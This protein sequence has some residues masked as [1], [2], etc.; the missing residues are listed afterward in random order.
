MD[1]GSASWAWGIAAVSA[2]LALLALGALW[3][4]EPGA[5]PPRLLRV[6][7]EPPSESVFQGRDAVEGTD[8]TVSPD[9]RRLAFVADD[10]I[11]IRD[12]SAT[13]PAPLPG[14]ESGRA[15]FWAPDGETLG[16][17]AG[18]MLRRVSGRG[19][20]VETIC[21]AEDGHGGSWGPGDQILFAPG[22]R[23]PILA[24][25]AGGGHPR[26][27]TEL[28]GSVH[29]THR[30]P[31]I[32]P[33]GR[34]FLFFA[35]SHRRPRGQE[36]GIYVASVAGGRARRL[37]VADSK[38][39]LSAGW[40]LFLRDG[41][42]MAQQFNIAGLELWGDAVRLVEDV[43][44]LGRS[45]AAMFSASRRDV[46]VYERGVAD[47]RIRLTWVDRLGN[48]VD[49]LREDLMPWDLRLSPDDSR[50]ALAAGPREPEIWIDELDGRGGARLP[51]VARFSR[52]PVWSPDGDQLAFAGLREGGHLGLFVMAADGTGE[53]RLLLDSAQDQ[54]PTSWSAD[55][56]WLA[57]EQGPAESTEIWI[58]PMTTQEVP[59][60]FI[61]DA[62]PAS[63]AQFSPDGRWLMFTSRDS[64]AAQVYITPFPGGG[65]RW[66]ISNGTWAGHGRWSAD[67]SRVFYAAAGSMMMEVA[68]RRRKRDGGLDIGVPRALFSFRA[69]DSV[70]RGSHDFYDVTG[71]EERF[72]IAQGVQAE[73]YQGRLMLVVP[74]TA[75][76][77]DGTVEG[78]N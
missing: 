78:G 33:D 48:E 18:G 15:P 43:R 28:D 53:A 77:E 21:E 69:N 45:W 62:G 25:D 56:R 9:G 24:V 70:Y 3:R 14:T 46:L 54:V 2:L 31:E 61:Q 10:Q 13:E 5:S 34:H 26:V 68:V 22:P 11:W 8:V 76:L 50:L 52:A 20:E 6:T 41:D 65:E 1:E 35:A 42:L 74:W 40:L 57:F 29:S 19:G 30:W 59:S 67:G 44:Y 7:L 39:V 27:V 55:G 51:G 4:P 23:S 73:R 47:R 17:F 64:G 12:L 63:D 60:A 66:Q 58:K 72:L 38:A 16:F 49:V 37:T 75:D 36:T 32:L 71:T